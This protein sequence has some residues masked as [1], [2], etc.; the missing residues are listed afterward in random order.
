MLT[1]RFDAYV[2]VRESLM[3]NPRFPR[4]RGKCPTDKG[5]AHDEP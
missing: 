4:E 1:A 5:G 3:H 2:D